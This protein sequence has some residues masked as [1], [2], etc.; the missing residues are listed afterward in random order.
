MI[1]R[2]INAMDSMRWLPGLVF[3]IGLILAMSDGAL[4][5]W[6]NLLGLGLIALIAW[7]EGGQG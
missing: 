1:Q 2:V 4:F 5:P 3:T 7:V 6:G